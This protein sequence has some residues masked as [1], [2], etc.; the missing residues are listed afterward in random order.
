MSEYSTR[1]RL[2]LV[3][4]ETTPGVD[5]SPTPAANAIRL[6]NPVSTP[7]LNSLPTDE[8]TGAL[9]SGGVVPSTATNNF[10][11]QALL[12]G[13]GS[14]G[15][16]PPPVT[17]FLRAGGL[18]VTA[19]AA[20]LT[21]TAQAGAAGS[22]TLAAG[23]SAVDDF[24]K[25]MVLETTG[26]AGSGQTRPIVGYNGTTK[27]ATV[28]PNWAVTPDGTTGYAV[29]KCH[30][31]KPISTGIPTLSIYEYGFRRDGGTA[32]L[33]KHFGASPQISLSMQVNDLCY[34]D[35]NCTAMFVDE[36]DA[37]PSGAGVFAPTNP[38]AL[39]NAHY[40]HLDGVKLKVRSLSVD[41]GN[42]I[43]Q[44]QNVHAPF[45]LDVAAATER[46]IAGEMS[47][48]RLLKSER[49]IVTSWRNGAESRFALGWG[50]VAGNR[51]SVLLDKMQYTGKSPD[52][53]DNLINERTPFVI[54]GANSG[55][56]I[57][58]W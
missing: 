56:Y 11:A 25:G 3:K 10:R 43:S 21:G 9:D 12:R 5:A 52:E 39:Q 36:E 7:T 22:I 45:G 38:I 14:A 53:Q 33:F 54:N 41:M 31:F 23:A 16:V 46:K 57:C 4:E 47:S 1:N 49:D 28:S 26:G 50:G 51:F 15:T 20:D 27:A 32:K 19:L 24:Y 34:W 13:S 58:Y 8:D 17:P 44:V 48:P 29:R 40:G 55:V 6:R 42:Q 2:I 35:I 30:L 18:G 37:D